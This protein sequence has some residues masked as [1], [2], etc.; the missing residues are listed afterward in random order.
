MFNASAISSVVTCEL[1][2]AELLDG[3]FLN[4]PIKTWEIA[5]SVNDEFE[6]LIS[7][8]LT[9]PIFNCSV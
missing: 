2:D 8:F 5:M 4:Q 1:S 9:A 3:F 7:L 6:N